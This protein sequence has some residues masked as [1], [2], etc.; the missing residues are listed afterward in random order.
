MGLLK[1]AQAS[2]AQKG[3][4]ALIAER[5]LMG[6]LIAAIALG[7]G[8]VLY[9]FVSALLWAAILVFA[10]WPGFIFMQRNLRLPRGLAAALL[11]A[12]VA[13]IVVLPLAL[14]APGGA[15]DIKAL[16]LGL[17]AW[18][19]DVPPAPHWLETLPMV[20]ASL[21]ATWNAWAGDLSEVTAAA[22]PYLG[23]AAERGLRLVVGLAGG[24]AE[25]GLAL[26]A[27]FFFL[28]S[29]EA[30]ATN[31]ARLIHRV[32][33]RYAPQLIEA[34][35]NTV[36]GAVY[37]ILGTA[38]LQG[39]LNAFGL[40]VAGVPRAGLLGTVTFFLAVLPIGAPVIW[41]PAGIWLLSAGQ[42]GHGIF[43]LTY[44]VLVVSGSDHV[45]RPYFISRGAHL[46]FLL[47]ILG[48]LG[49]VLA[50]GVLGIFLGP[51]LLGVGYTLLMAF[52]REDGAES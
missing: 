12:L 44:G 15:A 39:F 22:R 1:M 37:G 45:I 18:L 2:R 11:I 46:P 10:V 51:V 19:A 29:G 52:L 27:S 34:T 4:N 30:L 5:I 32:A 26:L 25:L 38:L 36:R 23:L 35:S 43:L 47:T 16:R 42:T 20:G 33:G 6:L 8:F 41:A 31:A 49:G 17:E 13:A 14:A 24:I 48:V 40:W 28:L 50:F 3:A 9:P 21:A 7:C